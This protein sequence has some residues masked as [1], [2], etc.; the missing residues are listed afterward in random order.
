MLFSLGHPHIVLTVQVLLNSPFH[1]NIT[2]SC[3]MK[4]QTASWQAAALPQSHLLTC[5]A[6]MGIDLPHIVGTTATKDVPMPT[7]DAA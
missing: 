3:G 7:S 1:F 5:R 6:N 2:L 4:W